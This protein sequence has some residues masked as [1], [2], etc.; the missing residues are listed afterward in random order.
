MRAQLVRSVQGVLGT[1]FSAVAG[2]TAKSKAA[3]TALA[4][5]KKQRKREQKRKVVSLDINMRLLQS[6]TPLGPHI[7]T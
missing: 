1:W 4:K 7:L 5:G 3:A 2:A 6:R